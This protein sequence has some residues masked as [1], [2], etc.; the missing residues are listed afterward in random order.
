MSV[1]ALRGEHPTRRTEAAVVRALLQRLHP[2]KPGRELIRLGP[3]DDG[4]YLVPDDL[5]GI[6]ACFSPGVNLV[7]GFEKD[8]AD[9][10]MK[11]FLADASVEKPAASHGLFTFTKK[12]VGVTTSSDYITVDDWVAAS[13]PGSSGDLLLQMDIEGC[14]YEV[15]L[16]MSDHVMRRFRIV[17]AEFHDVDQ[18]WNR[19]F[20]RL[21]SRAFEKLLQTHTCVHIHPNN[22]RAPLRR[23]GLSLPPL[24]EFTFLRTDRIGH[25]SFATTFPHPLDRDNT[26]K[27]SVPLPAC[28]HHR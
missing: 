23:R 8:C 25:R 22:D 24:V 15:L 16:G 21:A 17:V 4:G 2:L 28:W 20:F 26:G 12:F 1:L 18:L 13:L 11:V 7:S 5:H 14:E 10:G 19:P 3:Q 27:P 9:L 6:E